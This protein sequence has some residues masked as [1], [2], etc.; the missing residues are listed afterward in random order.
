MTAT[1][2]NRVK[3]KYKFSYFTY[4]AKS[5]IANEH[6]RNRLFVFH[7]NLYEPKLSI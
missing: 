4:Y 1:S 6:T 7:N 5:K 2:R 3:V